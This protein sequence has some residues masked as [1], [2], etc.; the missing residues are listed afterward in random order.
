MTIQFDFAGYC[1]A[2]NSHVYIGAPSGKTIFPAFWALIQHPT[3]GNLLFDT[4][5]APRFWDATRSF[6]EI[7]YRK[8][9]PV[10]LEKN[11]EVVSRLREKYHVDS[12]SIT[13]IILSHFHGDHVGGLKDFPNAQFIC[14]RQAYQHFQQF[15]SKWGI[16]KAYLPALIP[17][18]F[19]KRALFIEDFCT[20]MPHSFFRKEWFWAAAG[21]RF[22]ALPGHA[23][24]QVGVICPTEAQK[25][26]FLVADA[27]WHIHSIVQNVPPPP[28][29]R[30]FAD[31]YADLKDSIARLHRFHKANPSVELIP[32]HCLETLRKYIPTLVM[33]ND[34]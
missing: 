4:G 2:D 26:V 6:P 31:S 9:L 12:K 28:I 19:A 15:A 33:M 11:G 1:E 10:T 32:S 29:V 17:D 13:Y 14:T 27:V 18:D 7:L 25:E 24:G 5:Y 21:M 30:V 8:I 22:V 3:L 20:K 16:V 34:E 23:V